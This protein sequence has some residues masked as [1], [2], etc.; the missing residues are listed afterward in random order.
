MRIFLGWRPRVAGPLALVLVGGVMSMCRVLPVNGADAPPLNE[1]IELLRTHQHTYTPEDLNRLAV[2]GLVQKLGGLAQFVGDASATNSVSE[3]STNAVVSRVH[4]N[5]FGY[6]RLTALSGSTRAEVEQAVGDLARGRSI[7]GWVLDLR[8]LTSRDFSGAAQVADLFLP[9]GK[10]VMDWGT[11]L[12]QSTGR[13]NAALAIG[14]RPVTVLVNHQTRGG[15]E[16]VASVLRSAGAAV[17]IGNPTAGEVARYEEFA[18]STGRRL[19]LAVAPVRGGDGAFLAPTGVTPDIFVAVREDEEKGWLADP[20]VPTAAT[21]AAAGRPDG[22]G[23][24][25]TVSRPRRRLTE[26]D[27]VRSRR[28]GKANGQ[29]N[30]APGTGDSPAPLPPPRLVRD[31][32]LAHALDLLKGLSVI[33]PQ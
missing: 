6:L 19:R 4:E 27:L 26:A 12:F 21:T 33:R 5:Q 31:P 3:S 13:T 18:L 23:G 20:F 15:A 25:N 9:G 32:V 28:E 11:G 7:K 10:P 8:F 30:A 16:A 17:V 24:T 1:L 14:V 22:A 2:E 29:T